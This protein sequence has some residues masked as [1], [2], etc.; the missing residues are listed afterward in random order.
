MVEIVSSFLYIFNDQQIK[1]P[2]ILSNNLE[3]KDRALN[4]IP[5]VFLD[6]LKLNYI[7]SNMKNVSNRN[8]SYYLYPHHKI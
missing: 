7:I 1:I 6:I 4:H 3:D 8:K 2:T 5:H